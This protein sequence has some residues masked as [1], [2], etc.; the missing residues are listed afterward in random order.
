MEHVAI[1]RS[2]VDCNDS[3]NEYHGFGPDRCVIIYPDGEG[4]FAYRILAR[5]H[6]IRCRYGFAHR[7]RALRTAQSWIDYERQKH[8]DIHLVRAIAEA[9]EEDRNRLHA[10]NRILEPMA[11]D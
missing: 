4:R 6:E 7:D 3:S 11:F 1:Q 5:T 9:S 8:C 2:E 10:A